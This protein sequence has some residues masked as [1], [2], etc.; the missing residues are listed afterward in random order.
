[1]MREG[2]AA[3]RGGDYAV[4]LASTGLRREGGISVG[5]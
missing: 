2:L 5:R 1:M 3:R 4:G